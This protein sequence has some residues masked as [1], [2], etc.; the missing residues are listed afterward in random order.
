[1]TTLTDT[2]E[3]ARWLSILNSAD[4]YA[5]ESPFGDYDGTTLYDT[6]DELA[7]YFGGT[8]SIVYA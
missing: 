5:D 6:D 2:T 8:V 7:D 3:M 4:D 1:M